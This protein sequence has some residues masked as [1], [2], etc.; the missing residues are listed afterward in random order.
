M[1]VKGIGDEAPVGFVLECFERPM[2]RGL[3]DIL[4]EIENILKEGM[5]QSVSLKLDGPILY[6]R[7]VKESDS[8]GREG[9]SDSQMT[10][11]DIAR[12]V[13]LIECGLLSRGQDRTA[14]STWINLF[15]ALSIRGLYP[16]H[17]G[18]GA[19]TRLFDCLKLDELK[20]GSIETF[21]GSQ[22]VRD[23]HIPDDIGIVFAGLVPGGRLEQIAM[24]FRVH[25]YV[26]EDYKNERDTKEAVGFGNPTK[27]RGKSD[28][29][30][31][32]GTGGGHGEPGQF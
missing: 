3:K 9:H 2:P 8:E 16:T 10:L 25:L 26:E 13:P 14:D 21:F 1:N 6:E 5:V 28:G 31:A 17:L 30:M 7:L 22:I 32:S 19:Q 18:L 29:A 23:N 12:N 15:L 11:G 4:V 20:Y 27:E 24:G